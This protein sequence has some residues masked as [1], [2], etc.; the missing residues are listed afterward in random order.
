MSIIFVKTRHE[1]PS[2]VDFWKLVELSNFET[3]YIDEVDLSKTAAYIITPFNGEVKALLENHGKE[4]R[5]ALLI[6]WLLERLDVINTTELD[7]LAKAFD[8]IWVSCRYAKTLHPS[9][10]HVVLGS[11]PHLGSD[12]DSIKF[13]FTHQSYVTPRRK[14]V[15][16]RLRGMGLSEGPSGWGD[17][18][19]QVL[20]Q[21]ACMVH[22]QQSDGPFYTP[23]RFALAA[24]YALPVISEKLGDA[25]PLD[26]LPQAAYGDLHTLVEEVCRDPSEH[27]AKLFQ[28]LCL[29]RTFRSEVEKAL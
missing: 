4:P 26:F 29:D 3:V 23:L 20:K 13:D 19:D 2:Y 8:A 11:H 24:A 14:T 22:V 1:Y 12:P 15:Y 10:K 5:R 25:Y 27:G 18:R 28:A 9:F 17:Q 16:D 7:G 21:S 6:W